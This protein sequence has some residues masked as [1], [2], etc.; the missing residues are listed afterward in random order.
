MG[1]GLLPSDE[2]QRNGAGMRAMQFLFPQS[3]RIQFDFMLS[4][5]FL[6]CVGRIEMRLY[7]WRPTFGLLCVAYI[8]GFSWNILKN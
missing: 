3:L 4:L 8:N 5:H 7:C 1:Q 2:Q 6:F